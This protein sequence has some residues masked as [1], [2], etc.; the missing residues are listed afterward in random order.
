MSDESVI[1]ALRGAL[2][3]PPHSLVILRAPIDELNDLGARLAQVTDSFP[4]NVGVIILPK[5]VTTELLDED[6]MAAIGW[7]RAGVDE[8]EY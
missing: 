6:G 5:H 2:I 7:V 3:C 8:S 4:E 1:A